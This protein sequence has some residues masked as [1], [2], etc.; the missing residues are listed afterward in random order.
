M[1]RATLFVLAS[2]LS[3]SLPSLGE[4]GQSEA[5]AVPAVD[6]SAVPTYVDEVE[7]G[8]RMRLD[9][10][11]RYLHVGSPAPPVQ[12]DL[13]SDGA[14]D[15]VDVSGLVLFA[16][17]RPFGAPL[18]ADLFAEG[19]FDLL[20]DAGSVFADESS[21]GPRARLYSAFIGLSPSP[22][23]LGGLLAPYRLNLGRMTEMA[24]APVT[25]DGAS[26]EA[27]WDFGAVRVGA[28]AW[29][30]L[31]APQYL[32][33]DPFS[34]TDPGAY[35]EEHD[36]KSL[37]TGAVLVRRSFAP[38]PILHLVGGGEL[39]VDVFGVGARVSHAALA[40]PMDGGAGGVHRSRLQL[41]YGADF[42]FATLFGALEVD[43]TQLLPRSARLVVDGIT[44]DGATRAGGQLAVQFLEDVTALDG[45]FLAFNPSAAFDP[46]VAAEIEAARRRDGIR[47]LNLPPPAP[48]VL[49]V[50]DV[51]QTL[52]GPFS[53]HA[54]GR[55]RHHI[56]AEDLTVL[57]SN[58]YEAAAGAAFAPDAWLA[59]GLEAGGG[60]V[61]SGKNDP[62]LLDV[63]GEGVSSFVDTRLWARSALL[64]GKLSLQAEAFLRR[65][66]VISRSLSG[67]GQW[68]GAVSTSARFAILDF[69]SVSARVD[70][71]VL[72]PFDAVN[73]SSYAGAFAATSLAF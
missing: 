61:D 39:D 15:D 63:K 73:A 46:Q 38:E 25:Y 48:H 9:L 8:L 57:R 12:L 26:L 34:R 71:D 45:T 37:S 10:G 58:L 21:A 52:L 31:D 66:D 54:R 55:L 47:H 50:V 22:G 30:G 28:R 33:T 56:N 5:D 2:L 3:L 42:A 60:V 35:S 59:L 6:V 68:S 44:A 16:W 65:H 51:E 69:W 64:E 40:L 72:S 23:D 20:S 17:D 24:G 41:R 67:L 36:T 11:G 1:R 53:V 14:A 27:R 43:A 49:A 32:A 29:G 70:A 4:E 7:R 13:E 19:L 62:F 18:K